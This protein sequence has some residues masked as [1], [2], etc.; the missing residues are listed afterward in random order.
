MYLALPKVAQC[1]KVKSFRWQKPED[2]HHL[3][4]KNAFVYC[5]P[6]A[7]VIYIEANFPARNTR[8]L[9][10]VTN[11]IQ[12]ARTHIQLDGNKLSICMETRSKTFY[13]P[14]SLGRRISGSRI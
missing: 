1:I 14:C 12:Q 10:L 5:H 8:L 4:M 9:R 7:G 13:S 11:Q 6:M 3:Y 2:S